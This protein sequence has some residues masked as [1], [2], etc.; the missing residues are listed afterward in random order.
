M[1]GL[2]YAKLGLS[3]KNIV[4]CHVTVY[5]RLTVALLFIYSKIAS[6]IERVKN[7]KFR[8]SWYLGQ[9]LFILKF[10]AE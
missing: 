5:K 8:K 3:C 10:F 7:Y 4:V 2:G 9:T 6:T 1:Y